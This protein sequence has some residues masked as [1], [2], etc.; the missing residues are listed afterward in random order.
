MSPA[1]Q[2]VTSEFLMFASSTPSLTRVSYFGFYYLYHPTSMSQIPCLLGIK[3][4]CWWR[5]FYSKHSESL[6]P[7]KQFRAGMAASHT[8]NQGSRFPSLCSHSLRVWLPFSKITLWSKL[9]AGATVII[10]I[11]QRAGR[12]KGAMPS[13]IKLGLYS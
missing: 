13:R 3:F 8:K 4:T 5:S 9:T 10:F 2:P 6:E 12:A 1:F 11:F 7:S